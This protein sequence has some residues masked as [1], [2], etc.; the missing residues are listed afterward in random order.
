MHLLL[1]CLYITVA[2]PTYPRIADEVTFGEVAHEPPRLKAKPRGSLKVSQ[3]SKGHSL[4]LLNKLDSRAEMKSKTAQEAAVKVGG[5]KRQ[6]DIEVEREKAIEQYRLI[7]KARTKVD[8][9][10]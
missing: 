8:T 6:R 10:R 9:C 3:K 1:V 2:T 5:L 4:L 7:K